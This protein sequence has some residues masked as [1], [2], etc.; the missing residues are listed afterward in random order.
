MILT[1]LAEARERLILIHADLWQGNLLASETA[2][3][4][5]DFSLCG[6]GFPLFDLGTCLPSI[7]AHLR[8]ALLEAYQQ[9]AVLPSAYP[10]LIDAYFLLSRMGAYVYLLP[11]IAEREWLKERIPRF[12]AQECRLFLEEKPL[13]LG[14]PF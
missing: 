9:Q 4:P 5:I 8:P 6:F 7:P 12:V 13:L 11:N 3:H 1:T 10:R 2:V 14:G